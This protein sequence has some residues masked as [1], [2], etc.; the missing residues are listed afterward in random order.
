MFTDQRITVKYATHQ[1]QVVAKG[2]SG[3]LLLGCLLHLLGPI[4]WIIAMA[5]HSKSDE[6]KTALKSVKVKG[7]IQVPQCALCV[8][9]QR[10]VPVD[11]EVRS[12]QYAFEV[13]PNFLRRYESAN[14][15]SS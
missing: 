2:D 6:Q 3:P 1:Q 13:H 12:G 15:P 4:G 8:S 7:K 11:G 10:A 9:E 14:S 5:L